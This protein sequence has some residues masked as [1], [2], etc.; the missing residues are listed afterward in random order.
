MADVFISYAHTTSKQA[1]AAAATLR[2]AGHSVW[3]D[4]DLAAHREFTH[5]IEEQLNAAK[6]ALVIWSAD[7][8]KSAWVLSEANRA[9]EDGKLVQL[10]IDRTRLPMPFDQVQ[11]ADMSGWTGEVEHPN[12]RRVIASIRE[13]VAGVRG[14]PTSPPPAP[15]LRAASAEPL[16]AVLA[17][18]NLS[19]DPE[20]AFFSDGVSEE[21]QETVAKGAHLKVIGRASSFQFRGADKAAANVGAQLGASHV[22]DGSVR[23]SG[24]RVRISAQLVEC[25]KAT[26]LWSDR[27]DRELTD[28]FALQ[29][30]IAEAVAA[31]LRTAFAASAAQPQSIDPVAYDL[32]LK[33]REHRFTSELA[34]NPGTGDPAVAAGLFEQVVA[35]APN[36]AAAWEGLALARAYQIMYGRHP[37]ANPTLRVGAIDAANTALRLDPGCG[38]AYSA[39]SL[40]QPLARYAERLALIGQGLAAAPCDVR[41]MGEFGRVLFIVGRQDEALANI[42]QLYERDRLNQVTAYTIAAQTGIGGYYGESQAL[43]EDFIARWPTFIGLIV[44]ALNLAAWQGDWDRFE[45]LAGRAEANGL[46]GSQLYWAL[47]T[48]RAARDRD[49]ATI[50]ALGR[51]LRN[52]LDRT[53][54]V[55]LDSL[56]AASQLGLTEEAFQAVEAASFAH[57]FQVDGGQA[58]GGWS[59][60]LLFMPHANRAMIHDPRFVGLCAKIGLCDYWI[61][62]DHWPDCADQVPYDFRREAR[63]L[64]GAKRTSE[65]SP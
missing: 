11:C 29:D 63:R 45:T 23:R 7:A 36:F 6:A 1:Q 42:R 13:L 32:Y 37:Q 19:G 50:E 5:A 33:S 54:T 24:V 61:A 65:G 48:G 14:S 46:E 59:P 26:T 38:V 20:M 22:L 60:G 8:A 18:D 55:R 27:F 15:G 9:R 4:D 44:M 58:A 2:L 34:A 35:R 53:G 17:F 10:V 12:W 16:L 64:V 28:I 51:G 31:A 39:L 21:I 57:M 52:Q 40:L 30:E 43:F 49:E 62:T 41:V 3:L 56:F 47:R 25:A